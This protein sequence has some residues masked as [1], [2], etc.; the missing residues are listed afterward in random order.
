MAFWG[1]WFSNCPHPQMCPLFRHLR[2]LALY[3]HVR[4]KTKREVLK[5]EAIDGCLT[6]PHVRS[7]PV[8]AG[9]KELGVTELTVVQPH[10]KL[11]T[12]QQH[13]HQHATLIHSMQHFA[14]EIGTNSVGPMLPLTMWVSSHSSSR[15]GHS[16]ARATQ[17]PAEATRTAHSRKV[18]SACCDSDLNGERNKNSVDAGVA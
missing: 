11:L 2:Q 7:L 18:P 3:E 1:G 8:V 17:A 9:A 5:Q 10:Y 16:R 12:Q 14:A 13:Q 4:K 15:R 6:H